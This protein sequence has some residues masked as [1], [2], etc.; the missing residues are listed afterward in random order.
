MTIRLTRP[1]IVMLR[2]VRDAGPGGYRH[3]LQSATLHA[4]KV[5]GFVMTTTTSAS[6]FPTDILWVITPD[7]A[8]E[9]ALWDR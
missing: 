8:E 3:S 4:L 7:G 2:A 1:Q 6:Q 9:I 5:R